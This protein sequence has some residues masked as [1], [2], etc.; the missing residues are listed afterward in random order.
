ME[1]ATNLLSAHAIL[2]P[3]RRDWMPGR[4]LFARFARIRTWDYPCSAAG[5]PLAMKA[6]TVKAVTWYGEPDVRVDTAYL[7]GR[8]P[9]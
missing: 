4:M 7:P 2:E 6:M 1:S 5:T 9:A 8:S 3:S